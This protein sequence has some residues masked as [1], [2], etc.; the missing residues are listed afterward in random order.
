MRRPLLLAAVWLAAACGRFGF[1]FVEGVGSNSTS[2]DATGVPDD[3]GISSVACPSKP[4]VSGTMV[5]TASQLRAAITA[6]SPGDTIL[7]ADGLYTTSTTINVNVPN[8]TIRSA[9]NRADAAIVDGQGVADP[10]F[11]VRQANVAFISLTLRNTGSDSIVFEPLDAAGDATGALVYDVT[12]TDSRGPA[13]RAKS[14]MSLDTPPFAD[15]GTFACSRVAHTVANDCGTDGVF[16]ARLMGVRG[17]TIRDNYFSGQCGTARIRAIWADRG[18]RDISILGNVFANNGNNIMLGGAVGRTYPDALPAGCTG[19]PE[20][21]GGLVCNNRISAA[22]VPSRTMND[23][24]EGIALWTACDTWVLHNTIASPIGFETYENIE[25]RF[26]GSYVHLFNNVLEMA[27]L[28]RDNGMLDPTSAN[29][30]YTTL[31]VFVDANAGDLRPS[32]S[33]GSGAPISQCLTDA[34]GVARN[35]ISP[36]PGAFER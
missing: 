30:V 28:G 17:W 8:L 27:P 26:A 4:M 2:P 13:V 25:Y 22:I 32:S 21:W 20:V 34:N 7:L 36:I 15:G 12:F 1:D 3:T 16:G 18:A 11:Y 35:A 19:T 31:S 23:F 14:Y 29:N 5:T 9:S 24:E 10:I 33:F 6:A